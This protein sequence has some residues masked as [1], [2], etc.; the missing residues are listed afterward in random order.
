MRQIIRGLIVIAQN[1][2]LNMSA[3]ITII[4]MK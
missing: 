3:K 4:M 1:C 2:A